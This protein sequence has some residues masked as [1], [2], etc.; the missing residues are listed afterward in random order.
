MSAQAFAGWLLT[1]TVLV[2]AWHV[3]HEWGKR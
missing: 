2:I 1:F 3:V